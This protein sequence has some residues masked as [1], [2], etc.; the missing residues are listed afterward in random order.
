MVALQESGVGVA[1]VDAVFERHLEAIA[2]ATREFPLVTGG[3]ALGGAVGALDLGAEAR[4]PSAPYL[5]LG[6]TT[7]GD[8]VCSHRVAILSGSCS[9]ATQ[10]QVRR[11][12]GLVPS[13]PL[14]PVRLAD[15]EQELGR[16]ID[17][18]VDQSQRG[19]V[20]LYSTAEDKSVNAAHARLGRER[21]AEV[22]E[23]AFAAAASALA[24]A[25]VRRFV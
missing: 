9:A 13:R 19:A 10:S 14:D 5:P 3:A 15:D 12:S 11:M 17:W 7:L 6:P 24:A 23:I 8:R 1:I 16:V 18:A 25:G 2:A 20:M 22:T 4:T 21:A